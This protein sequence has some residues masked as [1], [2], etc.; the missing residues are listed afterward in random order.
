M[1]NSPDE[2]LCIAGLQQD[3]VKIKGV[4]QKAANAKRFH[5]FVKNPTSKYVKDF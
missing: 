1:E 4:N 3:R 2:I 5:D